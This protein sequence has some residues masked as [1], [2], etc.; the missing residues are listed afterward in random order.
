MSRRWCLGSVSM[1]A[2]LLLLNTPSLHIKSCTVEAKVAS[3]DAQSR[4]KLLLYFRCL[5]VEHWLTGRHSSKAALVAES[6]SALY[7]AMHPGSL[8]TACGCHQAF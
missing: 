4:R 5:L 8:L 6:L 3:S 1:L 7:A 2:A